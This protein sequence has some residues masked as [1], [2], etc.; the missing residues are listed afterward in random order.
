VANCL[1]LIGVFEA[2]QG[3][4]VRQIASGSVARMVLA[5]LAMSAACAAAARVL[6]SEL[7]TRG[8]VANLVVGLLPVTVGVALYVGVCVAL[9]IPEARELL[10]A[11]RR[12]GGRAASHR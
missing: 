12:R 11:L 7:G 10:V 2:R 8:I 4:L 5:A 3:G 9:R 1:V 6:S